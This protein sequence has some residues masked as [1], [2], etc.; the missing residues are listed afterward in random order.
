MRNAIQ[1]TKKKIKS[2][3]DE[4]IRKGTGIAYKQFERL[5]AREKTQIENMHHSAGYVILQIMVAVKCGRRLTIV[6]YILLD[7]RRQYKFKTLC[8]IWQ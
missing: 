5:T 2:Q 4:L 1:N 3:R 7:R 6:K 8:L